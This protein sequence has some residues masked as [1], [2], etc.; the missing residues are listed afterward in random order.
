[1]R[2]AIFLRAINV[3]KRRV[4]M[5]DVRSAFTDAGYDD[6][7]TY[8][9]SGNVV[10]TCATRPSA[11]AVSAVISDRFGF[12][13]E[14]F[15]RSRSEVRSI[16]DR[17]PWDPTTSTIEVSFLDTMP[18][19]SAALALEATALPPEE[20][21]VSER[22]VFFRRI[23]GGVETTHKEETT[24]RTL[25]AVTTRRGIRTVQGIYDRFLQE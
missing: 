25:G 11:A 5:S 2:Y 18:R 10:L 20:L 8:L 15:V 13:S 6:V 9:A 12:E 22:E 7:A 21:V 3:G 19:Q 17:T 4:K 24:V 1:M 14:A 16:L 23:G